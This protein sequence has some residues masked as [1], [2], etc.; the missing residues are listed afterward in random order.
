MAI[1]QSGIL[2]VDELSWGLRLAGGE[3]KVGGSP[4]VAPHQGNS[5]AGGCTVASA[6]QNV[7]R[8]VLPSGPAGGLQQDE[9]L[10]RMQFFVDDRSSAHAVEGVAVQDSKKAE[11]KKKAGEGSSTEAPLS[12]TVAADASAAVPEAAGK[13]KK[14]EKRGRKGSKDGND[15]H[16]RTPAQPPT[17]PPDFVVSGL[18]PDMG[19]HDIVGLFAPVPC[20]VCIGAQ[21]DVARAVCT[22]HCKPP[23]IIFKAHTS[24]A[25]MGNHQ[26]HSPLSFSFSAPS[27]RHHCHRHAHT[28][29]ILEQAVRALDGGCLPADS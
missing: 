2:A 8:N 3:N 24:L 15:K 25:L 28:A 29:G 17:W 7:S 9:L 13:A 14:T 18:T 6:S 16:G 21:C 4:T 5:L 20:Q 11:T 26:Q 12:G 10:T 22:V 1:V 23:R 19:R 27:N